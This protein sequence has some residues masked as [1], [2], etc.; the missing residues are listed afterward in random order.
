[1]AG[2]S[3]AATAVP[4]PPPKPVSRPPVP[5]GRHAAVQVTPPSKTQVTRAGRTLLEQL[6]S[7]EKP[8]ADPDHEVY[9]A[10]RVV[11]EWRSLHSGPLALVT[12]E[13]RSLLAAE[14][15]G[16]DVGQRLKRMPQI[17]LKLERFPTMRLAQMSD[18]AGCR[19]VLLDPEEVDAVAERIESNWDLVDT[20]DYRK[21]GKPG[22]G[23]RALHL[24]V[25]R[26]G[27]LVEIQLRTRRQHRWAEVIESSSDQMGYAFKDGQGPPELLDYFR[28]ASDIYWELD[29]GREPDEGLSAELAKLRERVRPYYRGQAS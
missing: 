27:Y 10:F 23:Y 7:P 9:A 5:A 19:A 14:A 16:G 12:P 1:V 13:L 15:P 20:S 4:A 2:A 17:M 18:I 28:V 29:N 11:N 25:Q 21:A 24:I 6:Q 26:D 22:T 8:P 3:G